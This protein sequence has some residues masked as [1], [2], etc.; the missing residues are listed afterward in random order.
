MKLQQIQDRQTN[1]IVCLD[2]SSSMRTPASGV[3][4]SCYDVGK[5]MALYFSELLIGK[6]KNTL[7]NFF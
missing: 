6:F 3:N 7:L 2:I 4:M 1:F 5:A